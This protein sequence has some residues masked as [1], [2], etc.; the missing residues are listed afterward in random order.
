MWGM[1]IQAT[2]SPG[3]W[4]SKLLF[5]GG[6]LVLG[7]DTTGWLPLTVPGNR[8]DVCGVFCLILHDAHIVF[9][10]SPLS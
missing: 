10:P 2:P 7:R 3:E 1:G 6:A 8:I 4:Q 5:P 9:Y